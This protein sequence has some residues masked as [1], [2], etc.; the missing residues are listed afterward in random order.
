MD[1]PRGVFEHRT[2]PLPHG[3]Q[4]GAATTPMSPASPS[5]GARAGD[6]YCRACKRK[7]G[8]EATFE[9]HF[10]SERHRKA[11]A[12]TS[13]QSPT[14]PRGPQSTAL[15][16]GLLKSLEKALRLAPKDPAVAAVVLWGIA[17]DLEPHAECHASLQQALEATQRC[18]RAM[19]A[20]PA[21]RNSGAQQTPWTARLLLKTA[22]ECD[23]ALA[24]L[25]SASAK[26]R[27]AAEYAAALCRFV[28]IEQGAL[29]AVCHAR[30]PLAMA[31]HAARV[32]VAVPRKFVKHEDIMQA[33]EAMDEAASA[34]LAFSTAADDSSL[35]QRGLAVQFVRY[36]FA[37]NKELPAV[38]FQTLLGISSAY[39]WL[40]AAHYANE[41]AMLVITHHI[42]HPSAS[43]HVAAAVVSSIRASDLVRARELLDSFSAKRDEPWARFLTGLV[44]RLVCAD[45]AWLSCDARSEWQALRSCTGPDGDRPI[46]ELADALLASLLEPYSWY[47]PP[48]PAPSQDP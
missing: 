39:R 29:D 32:V 2:Y 17:R 43:A 37:L 4:S 46:L 18:L 10:G 42:D 45:A 12:A 19:E 8:S 41:C 3:Q 13:A 27:A 25:Q 38:A 5:K 48:S 20:D 47:A 31:E 14:R 36:A 23:L 9:V 33:L 28:G 22:L 30:Q 44:A 24:R 26:P 7:F 21:L 40:G 35:A 11:A 16:D 15:P 1:G 6:L 34:H